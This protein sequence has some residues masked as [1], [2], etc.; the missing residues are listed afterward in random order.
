MFISHVRLDLDGKVYMGIG[1][2]LHQLCLQK[3]S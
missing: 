2:Q 3:E 1:P